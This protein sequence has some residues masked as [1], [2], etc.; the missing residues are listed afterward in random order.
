MV[1]VV[2]MV[3]MMPFLTHQTFEKMVN[4]KNKV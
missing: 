3:V 4:V 2:A 1:M